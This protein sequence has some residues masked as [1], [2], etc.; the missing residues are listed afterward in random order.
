MTK[1]TGP[2]FPA[3]DTK[4]D[5]HWYWLGLGTRVTGTLEA[6]LEG[7]LLY[8]PTLPTLVQVTLSGDIVE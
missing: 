1:V 4:S 5:Q 2:S 6:A 8:A 3:H 7:I